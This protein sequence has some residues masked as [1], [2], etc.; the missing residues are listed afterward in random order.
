MLN[1]KQKPSPLRCESI[2]QVRT[3][4]K[5]RKLIC[6]ELRKRAEAEV[7]QPPSLTLAV[8]FCNFSLQPE[9]QT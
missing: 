5:G 4:P 7:N 3:L 2:T 1:I 8:S 9:L 6:E